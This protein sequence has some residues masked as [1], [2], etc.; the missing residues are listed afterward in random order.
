VAIRGP[1]QGAFETHAHEFGAHA[2]IGQM[3]ILLS[4]APE[5]VLWYL[6]RS[7]VGIE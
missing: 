3:R 7:H 5:R 4:G 1:A 6:T 2:M